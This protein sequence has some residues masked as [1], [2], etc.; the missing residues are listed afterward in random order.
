MN[1]ITAFGIK[2]TGPE[3]AVLQFLYNLYEENKCL[4]TGMDC[5]LFSFLDECK[6]A[7]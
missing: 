3:I 7:C 2:F 1:Y 6:V 4:T 5:E